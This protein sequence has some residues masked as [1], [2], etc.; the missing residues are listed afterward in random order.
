MSETLTFDK[1]MPQQVRH[2]MRLLD[3]QWDQLSDYRQG[4]NISGT[5]KD[6]GLGALQAVRTLFD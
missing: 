2:W 5:I 3:Q 1:L 4:K 6:A